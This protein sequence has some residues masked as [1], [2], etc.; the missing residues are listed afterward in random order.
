MIQ[1]VADIICVGSS[2]ADAFV[3]VDGLHN[4]GRGRLQN[5]RSHLGG[6]G[7]AWYFR[8]LGFLESSLGGW[9]LVGGKIE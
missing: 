1:T 4:G 3:L 2:A 7:N 6:F 9:L 8:L 5:I